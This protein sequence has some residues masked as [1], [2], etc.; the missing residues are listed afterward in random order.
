MRGTLTMA[1]LTAAALSVVAHPRCAEGQ[2]A[3]TRPVAGEKYVSKEGRFEV[4]F[5]PGAKVNSSQEKRDG[6]ML[7]TFSC[8]VGNN[9]YAVVYG[10]GPDTLRNT[11]A[12]TLF[13]GGTKSSLGEKG[14]LISSK[15]LWVG[16]KKA[17]AREIVIEKV[18]VKVRTRMILVGTRLYVLSVGSDQ[19][20]A[21]SEAATKFLD[22]F[23]Y[24]EVE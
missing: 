14:K 5:P 13:D 11:P 10:D 18:G 1:I 16:L 19:D 21:T 22:S 24:L 4:R 9:V 6:F 15:E 12:K 20:F 2:P 23:A 3:P 7:H 8:E 17:P